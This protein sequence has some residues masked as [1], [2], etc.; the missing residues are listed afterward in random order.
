MHATIATDAAPGHVNEDF[1]AASTSTAVL[2]DGAGLSGANDGG[3]VHGVAWYVHQ[4]GGE[5]LRV[6]DQ[7]P[8]AAL[9][10]TLAQAIEAVARSHQDTCDLGHPGTPSSTVVIID[11]RDHCLR[12]LV[13]ADSTLVLDYGTSGQTAICDDREGKLGQRHRAA[14]DAQEGG[15]TAHNMARRDYVEAMLAYRNRPGGFWVAATAPEAAHHA[16]TG[17]VDL[18]TSALLVSDGAAR[19]VDR[20]G[21]ASWKDIS[22]LV[23]AKGVQALI[24]AN[25]DAERSDPH[26]QRWPRGKI[27]DDCT[28]VLCQGWAEAIT[29]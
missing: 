4:L 19:V 26:G 7:R 27:F 23:A 17:E 18:P 25:R 22:R 15:T 3:C 14:M 12:Y 10:D 29:P 28:A 6:T 11:V 13:L 20:F 16:L 2:L 8:G 1:A 9:P 24:D 5:I 21:L